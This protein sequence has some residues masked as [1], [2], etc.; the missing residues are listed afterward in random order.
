MAPSSSRRRVLQFGFAPVL[1][2]FVHLGCEAWFGNDLWPTLARQRRSKQLLHYNSRND[3]N[4]QHMV[5]RMRYSNEPTNGMQQRNQ[6]VS[7]VL[8]PQQIGGE[9]KPV[10]E[11]SLLRAIEQVNAI[12]RL[13][14]ESRLDISRNANYSSIGKRLLDATISP[15]VV[16]AALES[17]VLNARFELDDE[18][19]K[20]VEGL[21]WRLQRAGLVPSLAVMETLWMML[22]YQEA[23]DSSK[24]GEIVERAATVLALWY[25]WA[26]PSS[27]K[28]LPP[29]PGV[30]LLKVLDS[31]AQQNITMSPHI[32]D[33][34]TEAHSAHVLPQQVFHLAFSI[35]SYSGSEWQIRTCHILRSM[36]SSS[37]EYQAS[38][39]QLMFALEV[40][41]T[42]GRATDAA[43]LIRLLEHD[44][45][46]DPCL[47]RQYF[48]KSL[49]RSTE[50]GSLHYMERYVFAQQPSGNETMPE[51]PR[52]IDT[53]KM[54]L[55]KWSDAR[56]PGAGIRAEHI[57]RCCEEV[58]R[59]ET[60]STLCPDEECVYHV[61]MAYLNEHS[62]S[63]SHVVDAS[64]FVRDC[65]SKQY[66]SNPNSNNT[67]PTRQSF[68]IFDRLLG[69]F[70]SQSSMDS[71]AGQY[72]DQLFRFFIIQHRS[73]NVSEEPGPQ[74][75]G[76]LL[77]QFN[78]SPVSAR[79]VR[80]GLE[81]FQLLAC[82][83]ARNKTSVGPNFLNA[84]QL[85]GLLARTNQSQ[86][87]GDIGE[88]ILNSVLDE[89]RPDPYS[90]GHMFWCVIQC[91]CNLGNSTYGLEAAMRVLEQ[92]EDFH[93][94][95]PSKLILTSAPYQTILG[96]VAA[97]G[98]GSA[99]S[100]LVH[101]LR[102]KMDFVIGSR[103][104]VA[105]LPSE[106]LRRFGA[107]L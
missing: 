80:K 23:K 11:H 4:E 54:L 52:W 102:E 58:L 30:Y 74:H 22:Q 53:V 36:M 96:T 64:N 56:I 87:Y 8:V 44:G 7:H 15:E 24:A 97:C 51:S 72:S 37:S 76:R 2:S 14:E 62:V 31:A 86:Y 103:Q 70:V 59:Q 84:R 90:L 95:N 21:I 93:L 98:A 101:S 83:H 32:W 49:L 82:L 34:Y 46:A 35:L 19:L 17:V 92:M 61:V 99:N 55:Q 91:H 9:T 73:R 75:L 33:V 41:S 42:T 88:A 106:D 104:S 20:R 79:S 77:R 67:G 100:D 28:K 89:T 18:S 26:Q 63:L 48:I 71:K 78:R 69:S 12:L 5:P 10:S 50:P 1:V 13:Y 39:A 81:Y 16:L 25:S 38:V 65:V 85:L 6:E 47:L 105:T 57:F 94:Q 43:W 68:P 45:Q 60:N 40:S 3:P 29:P 107:V 27:D 66:L